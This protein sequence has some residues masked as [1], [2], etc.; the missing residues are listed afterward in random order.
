MMDDDRS[1]WQIN[2]HLGGSDFTVTVFCG[3][4]MRVRSY[5]QSQAQVIFNRPIA[6]YIITKFDVNAFNQLHR[7]RFSGHL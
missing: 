5:I 3:R 4:L 1:A 7:H 2:R 6:E